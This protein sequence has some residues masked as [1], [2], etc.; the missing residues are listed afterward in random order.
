MNFYDNRASNAMA[1]LFNAKINFFEKA[2][3]AWQTKSFS[4]SESLISMSIPTE[5]LLSRIISLHKLRRTHLIKLFK[6]LCEIR[7]RGKA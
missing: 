6:A 7:S 1:E 2:C 5:F 4:F 3:E